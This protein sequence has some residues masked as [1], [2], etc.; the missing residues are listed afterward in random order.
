[1]HTH[2]HTHE[3]FKSVLSFFWLISCK[4][5]GLTTFPDMEN[6]KSALKD[7]VTHADLRYTIREP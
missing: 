5:M 2:T 4:G 7:T 6:L 3:I 1:M